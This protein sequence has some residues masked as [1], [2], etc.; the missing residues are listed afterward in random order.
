MLLF[1][2]LFFNTALNNFRCMFRIEFTTILCIF[3]YFNFL[4][5][6]KLT[7]PQKKKKRNLDLNQ[8]KIIVYNSK[9]NTLKQLLIAL[10]A[11]CSN[12]KRECTE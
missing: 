8:L 5:V 9:N 6:L 7:P 1:I 3:L 2:I 4:H 12:H 10:T 11:L